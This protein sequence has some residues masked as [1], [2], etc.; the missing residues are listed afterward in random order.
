MLVFHHILLK[1]FVDSLGRRDSLIPV[2]E[3]PD[4][5]S[6]LFQPMINQ[7]HQTEIIIFFALPNAESADFKADGVNGM[8]K[9][10]HNSHSLLGNQLSWLERLHGMQEVTGSTPVISTGYFLKNKIRPT[11]QGRLYYFFWIFS[12]SFKIL[13]ESR[14]V[15][16][17]FFIPVIKA[18]V[19]YSGIDDYV[20]IGST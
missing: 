18:A 17:T 15:K 10:D 8:I 12:R 9:P 16:F 13:L 14:I 3:S 1:Y 5:N 7:L 2:I 6:R 20:V 19:A 4:G 11:H